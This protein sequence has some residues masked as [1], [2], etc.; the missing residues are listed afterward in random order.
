MS[1]YRFVCPVCEQEIEVN[2]S[3]R[4]AILESGCPVCTAGVDAA[5]FE[6]A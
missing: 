5:H 6:P 3:M 2:T 1:T 4:E